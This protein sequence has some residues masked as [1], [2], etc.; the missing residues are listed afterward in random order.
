MVVPGCRPYSK[1]ATPLCGPNRIRMSAL[2]RKRSLR[3]SYPSVPATVRYR[4]GPTFNTRALVTLSQAQWTHH[5]PVALPSYTRLRQ[6]PILSDAS[7]EQ[8]PTTSTSGAV[9]KGASQTPWQSELSR[10]DLPPSV[11][12]RTHVCTKYVACSARPPCATH[13]DSPSR[14]NRSAPGAAAGCTQPVTWAVRIAAATAE[15]LKRLG[16]TD[17]FECASGVGHTSER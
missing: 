14:L 3:A 1:P 2:G 9:P 6:P 15:R 16:R 10:Q 11:V 12:G 7:F 13:A 5:S 4:P 17:M 8:V